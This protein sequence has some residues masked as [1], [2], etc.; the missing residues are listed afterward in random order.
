MIRTF[1]PPIVVGVNATPESDAALRWAVHEAALRE[2]PL[3]ILSAY[4]VAEPTPLGLG[5]TATVLEKPSLEIRAAHARARQY[6]NDRLESDRVSGELVHGA[7]TPS[8]RKAAESAA[9]L[10]VGARRRQAR[11]SVSH[12]VAAHAACPVVVV[13]Q[14]RSPAADRIVVGVDGSKESE[15]AIAFALEEAALRGSTVDAVHSWLPMGPETGYRTWIEQTESN[16]QQQLADSLAPYRAK[17]PG[18]QVLERVLTG[19]PAERL[20]T[21]SADAGLVV[22]GSRGLGRVVGAFLGSVSQS[23]LHHAQGVVAVVKPDR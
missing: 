9:V 3:H 23:L 17:Y 16:F 10:V 21:L 5:P 7:A 14:P 18:V 11:R 12:S 6:A 13:R 15:H 22:V 8:L 19:P 2:R 4:V 1:G 20:A